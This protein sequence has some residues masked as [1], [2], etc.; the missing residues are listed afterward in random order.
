MVLT[1]FILPIDSYTFCR[2]I[3]CKILTFVLPLDFVYCKYVLLL[4]CDDFLFIVVSI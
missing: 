3:F 2:T 4:F 1:I